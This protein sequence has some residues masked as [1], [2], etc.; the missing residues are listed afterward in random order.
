MNS[1]LQILTSVLIVFQILSILYIFYY[2]L[3]AK[4]MAI[5]EKGKEPFVANRIHLITYEND[6]HK[7]LKNLQATCK[8]YNWDLTI[9]GENEI[10]YGFGTKI[11]RYTKHLKTINDDDIVIIIDARDVLLNATPETFLKRIR[12]FDLKNKIICSAEGGCCSIGEPHVSTKVKTWMEKNA[13]HEILKYLNTGMICGKAI[14]MK[15]VYP[16]DMKNESQDDQNAAVVYW[17][18]HRDEI[19]LDY[20]EKLF[21]NSEFSPNSDGYIYKNNHWISHTT[22]SRPVFIQTQAKNWKCYDKVVE[23]IPEKYYK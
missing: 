17:Y 7:N 6:N 22:Q 11:F 5:K 20:H 2:L 23:K 4:K 16:F 3:V 14:N 15:K 9:L 13:D 19:N 8:Q 12:H 1:G 21:S 18:K 10:W